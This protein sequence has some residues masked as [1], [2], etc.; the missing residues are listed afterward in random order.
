MIEGGGK[1]KRRL[2][3]RKFVFAKQTFR[4]LAKRPFVIIIVYAMHRV[5]IKKII[6]DLQGSSRV[7]SEL[8]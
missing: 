5:L 4:S 6:R 1:E 8:L 3:L 7:H 2:R